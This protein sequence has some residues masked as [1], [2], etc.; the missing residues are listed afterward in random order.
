MKK[1]AYINQFSPGREGLI[2]LVQRPQQLEISSL[3]ATL[4]VWMPYVSGAFIIN[5]DNITS[6]ETEIIS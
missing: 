5:G 2:Y 6:Q 4:K 1:D 3:A